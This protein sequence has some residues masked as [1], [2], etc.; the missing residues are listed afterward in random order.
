MS[1]IFVRNLG[2]S[3][4]PSFIYPRNPTHQVRQISDKKSPILLDTHGRDHTYLRISLTER[5]NLRCSYCMPEEGVPL[6]PN[7]NLLQAEEIVKLVKLFV[8]NGVNKIRFTGGEPLV[9]KDCVDIIKEI[10]QIDGLKKI[11][12]TTNGI[13]LARKLG[14]L[15][16][17][18]LNQLNISL[19]TL[20]EKKFQFI[21]KRNGFSKVMKGIDAALDM[22]FSPLKVS[23]SYVIYI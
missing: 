12:I 11:G 9:R 2:T 15:K 19:D 20:E 1:R 3:I 16:A 14:A 7:T 6:T 23:S 21:T 8:K 4:R 17:A 18:G 10:S 22:G 13:V 5:C